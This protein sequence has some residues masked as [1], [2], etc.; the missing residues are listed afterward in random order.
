MKLLITNLL[1][2]G[3]C[4]IIYS[5]ENTLGKEDKRERME[6]LKLQ[7]KEIN[8]EMIALEKD[9]KLSGVEHELSPSRILVTALSLKT[10]KFHHETEIRASVAS[11][12]NVLLAAESMG[13]IEKIY[14]SEGQKVKKGQLLV[15]LNSQVLQNSL[16]EIKTQLELATV[17]FEKQA[18]LW[19]QNI[20]TEIQYLQAKNNRESLDHRLGTLKS[21]LRMSRIYAP[22]DG[23]VDK[24][25]AKVGEFSQPGL[26]MVRIINPE[27]NYLKAD[28]SESLLG[29]FSIG[30]TVQIYFPN[31]NQ[32]QSSVISAIGQVINDQNRT[33]ELEVVMPECDFPVRPNQVVVIRLVDY[34]ND[35]AM[36]VP[37]KLI[38]TDN[39]GSFIYVLE[40]KS[41]DKK[42][43]KAYVNIGYSF[44]DH[45]EILSGL[46]ENQ[47]IVEKGYRALT[48]GTLVEITVDK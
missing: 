1:L 45:T 25:V 8:N 23:V 48:Q 15:T 6:L 26:P 16:E 46:V 19:N 2:L 20:G 47:M 21:Q 27:S 29:K 32:N 31:Q 38:Q 18:N 43:S 10:T 39:Q 28:I 5:C 13:K 11:R 9:L 44:D 22:F 37:T 17:L 7:L 24:I 14:V 40:G 42:A 34:L 35:R 41:D 30:D 36:V 33:F 12:K 4:M 3:I